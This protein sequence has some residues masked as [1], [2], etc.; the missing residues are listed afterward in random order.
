MTS[1]FGYS[2]GNWDPESFNENKL[3]DHI[4]YCAPPN[5]GRAPILACPKDLLFKIF[6]LCSWSYSSKQGRYGGL[7]AVNATCHLFRAVLLE[8]PYFWSCILICSGAEMNPCFDLFV[9]RGSRRL[10]IIAHGNFDAPLRHFLQYIVENFDLSKLVALGPRIEF[11]EWRIFRH[12][13]DK[14]V[15]PLSI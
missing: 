10:H 11:M 1:N 5:G 3:R 7:Q 4:L 2:F 15:L 13:Y 12:L 9:G 6:A 14:S 8:N